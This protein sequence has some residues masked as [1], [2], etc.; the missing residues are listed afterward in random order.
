VTNNPN[1]QPPGDQHDHGDGQPPDS[2]NNQPP[3]DNNDPGNNQPPFDNNEPNY[4]QPPF[5]GDNQG[6][7]ELPYYNTGASGH[8]G[9]QYGRPLNTFELDSIATT[10]ALPSASSLIPRLD[11]IGAYNGGQTAE[12]KLAGAYLVL[13]TVAKLIVMPPDRFTDMLSAATVYGS[14][15]KS[16][17]EANAATVRSILV[18]N[19]GNPGSLSDDQLVILWSG[20]EHHN[21]HAVLFGNPDVYDPIHVTSLNDDDGGSTRGTVLGGFND[22]GSWEQWGWFDKAKRFNSLI[23]G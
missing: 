9:S 10:L 5:V 6:S 1:D 8:Q 2:N 3:F 23:L 11:S 18:A 12:Q 21:L 22:K 19:V 16:A 4:S 15:K 13:S 17:M 14:L 7:G 20:N